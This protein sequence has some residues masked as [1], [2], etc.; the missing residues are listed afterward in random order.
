MKANE[1]RRLLDD[2]PESTLRKY[3]KDYAEYLSPFAGLRHREYTDLD[4][5]ILRLIV[6]MKAKRQSP[7]DID[8]TL[9]SLQAGDWEQLPELEEAAQSLVPTE[10]AMISLQSKSSALQREIAV[11]REM[12][13]K[14][15]ADRSELLQKIGRLEAQVELYESGRLSPPSHPA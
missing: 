7:D 15:R 3:A 14:E 13:D 5:R 10:S 11:L 9:R 12:L 8:V 1:V 2:L 6:D 4:A